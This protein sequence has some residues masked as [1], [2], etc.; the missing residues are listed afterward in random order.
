VKGG[1]GI[2][3]I[4]PPSSGVIPELNVILVAVVVSDRF[5]RLGRRRL[6][7]FRMSTVFV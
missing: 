5:Q 3:V 2:A 7:R 1:H 6:T 4:D